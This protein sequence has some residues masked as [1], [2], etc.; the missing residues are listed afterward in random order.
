MVDYYLKE[1]GNKKYYTIKMTE[2]IDITQLKKSTY[3][4]KQII[5]NNK[6]NTLIQ[7]NIAQ[8][9]SKRSDATQLSSAQGTSYTNAPFLQSPMKDYFLNDKKN[10]NIS[11]LN[12]L[13]N[14]SSNINININNNN[15]KSNNNSSNLNYSIMNNSKIP[16]GDESK[17]IS[18]LNI[19]QN[20]INTQFGNKEQ[21]KMMHKT[22]IYNLGS[23]NSNFF[24]E[25]N[26]E[27]RKNKIREKFIENYTIFLFSSFG[28]VIALSVVL[29]ILKLK[30]IYEYKDLYQFNIYMEILK[31]NTYLSA[32]Y[33]FTLCFQT[34]LNSTPYKI[35]N[36]INPKKQTLQD[37]IAKFNSYI[38][39]I[40]T[41]NKLNMLY[42]YIYG[43]YNFTVIEKSWAI[44]IRQ[45][46][47]IEEIKLILFYL[48]QIYF[49]DNNTCNFKNSFFG[50]NYENL[51]ENDIPPSL[52]EQFTFY[53]LQNTFQSFKSIF[54][55]VT[56]HTSLI[57]FD[58]YNGYFQ[59][60][61]FYGILII[62]F[63][64]ICY[65]IILEKLTDDKNE[66]KKLLKHL[67]VI[68]GNNENQFVFEIQ[69]SC[70]KTMCDNFK[71]ENIKRFEKSK[72]EYIDILIKKIYS[73]KS[74]KKKNMNKQ[75]FY[76]DKNSH[77]HKNKND[78]I[79]NEESQNIEKNIYLPKSVSISY[80]ILTFFLILI[81][82]IVIINIFYAHHIKNTFIFSI[83]IAMNFLERIPKCFELVFYSI[84]SFTL[85]DSSY[86]GNYKNYDLNNLI[87]KYL[88]YYHTKIIFENNTQI[89]NLKESYYPILFVE[90]R[91]VE[92]NIGIF[93]GKKT[94]ILNNIKKVEKEFNIND[95]LCYASSINSLSDIS[96]YK[97][98]FIEYF[99]RVSERMRLCYN[100]NFGSM[101]YGLLV[102][103]NYIYQEITNLFYD[104]IQSDD[105]AKMSINLFSLPD[106]NRMTL[107]FNY[108]LEYVFKSYS[109]SVMKD[110]K[111]LYVKTIRLEMLLSSLLLIVLFFVVIYVFLLIGKG[112]YKYKKLLKFFYKMY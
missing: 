23:K 49:L 6:K 26:E 73:K 109:H 20:L 93:L 81:S 100:N 16:L 68:G 74:E 105:K 45:S 46:N 24:N 58:Y 1:M 69:V 33:S 13:T 54:E 27:K 7:S 41:N 9:T 38:D 31:S 89:Y 5:E 39:R 18:E 103:I 17:G 57:L 59:F 72:N 88:N 8:L 30:K 106:I 48:Y 50:K 96:N 65:F 28:V 79:F 14:N 82:S 80:S 95:N 32:L 104:F 29:L 19:I 3:N 40:K 2:T 112:N 64:F 101:K 44:S 34:S 91:M 21:G 107:D 51:N 84:I 36:F 108:V 94:S 55:K 15:N 111:N 10:N 97:I 12:D 67:F 47:I 90:G 62:F 52:L 86:L 98:P 71:E 25:N 70:F 4:L 60:I 35:K 87:D 37:D 66:I 76:I 43:K 56:T 110:I 78:K 77:H 11:K 92:N 83:I 99:S 63:T 61:L 53:G 42:D 102:E 85:V 22:Q 75:S